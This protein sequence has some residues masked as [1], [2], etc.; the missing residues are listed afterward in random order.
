MKMRKTAIS[1]ALALLL[2]LELSP[3][4]WDLALEPQPDPG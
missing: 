2:L 4:A 3:G 1:L